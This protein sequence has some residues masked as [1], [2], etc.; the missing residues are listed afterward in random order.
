MLI[1]YL[2]CFSGI[3]GNMLLGALVDAGF[4]ENELITLPEVLGLSEG[5]IVLERVKRSGLQAFLVDVRVESSPP[6]RHFSDIETIITAS[7]LEAPV[8]ERSL[9]VFRRLAEAE[10]EVHGCLFE[11]VHFH[12]VGGTD[13]VLDITGAVLGLHRLGIERL[14][15]SPLP[16]TRGWVRCAHGEIPL[17]APA[18]CSLLR[19]VPVYGEDLDQELV[20]PTGAAIVKEMAAEFGRL[21]S[22]NPM[23]TGY[24]AGTM[25]RR[26]ERPNL[27][28][29]L[30]GESFSAPEAQRVEVIET[31]L[32]DWS[33]ETWPYVA[34]MLMQ[35]GALDVSLQP[36]HMKKGRPGFL[37]RVICDPAR[38]TLL[39]E[40]IL[41]ETSAIGL[42]FRFEERLTLEREAT[43]VDTVYGPVAA[44]KIF[45]PGGVTLTPEYE[46]CCRVAA[47]SHVS[48]K[49]VY[50]AVAAGAL[51]NS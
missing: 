21:P 39:K 5:R 20:T 50:A 10:A 16:L 18:V 17:P 46:D 12:E 27:L 2:D 48:L 9:A 38:S 45:D 47:E 28:R 32:D 33:P 25:Q 31:N 15:C 1:A 42:R 3:S 43:I 30:V 8:R 19:D 37:L 11:E 34:E 40:M 13:A 49:K 29:L 14:I 41:R 44:K 4:S 51:S 22:M 6:H 24:G 26:D 35:T 23:R 7:G 36:I